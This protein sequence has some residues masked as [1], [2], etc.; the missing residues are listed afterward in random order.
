MSKPTVSCEEVL[1]HL[2]AYLDRET[3]AHATAEIARHLEEC[4]GCFS[5]AEF[6]RQLKAH[7]RAAGSRAAPERLRARMKKLVDEF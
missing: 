7:V 1:K 6:E 2:F 5:R 3:D 4:R